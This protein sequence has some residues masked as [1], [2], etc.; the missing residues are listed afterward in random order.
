MEII[1]KT[2]FIRISPRKLRLVADALKHNIAA[3]TALNI[4]DNLDPRG[5]EQIK[6]TLNQAVANAQINFQQDMENLK[7][8]SIQI[9][10]GPSLKRFTPVSR[11]SA[12]SILKRTSHI[13][14]VLEGIENKVKEEVKS[15]EIVK[16]KAEKKK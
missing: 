13:T 1:A 8:K 12:H 11:G 15:K 10:G 6:K 14:V 9:D 3:K 5:A 7:I 2:K 4:L 16:V